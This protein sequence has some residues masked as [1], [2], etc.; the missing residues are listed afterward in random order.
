MCRHK[1]L[2]N[3][4]VVLAGGADPAVTAQLTA[5]IGLSG[6]QLSDRCLSQLLSP[7]RKVSLLSFYLNNQK[8]SCALIKRIS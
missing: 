3:V 2:D 7:V 8:L 5:A 4:D 6:I 1:R